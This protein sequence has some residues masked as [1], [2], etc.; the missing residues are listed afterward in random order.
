MATEQ[1]LMLLS[2]ILSHPGL[3]ERVE[4]I[5]DIAENTSGE[6]ITADQAEGKAIE[7]VQKLGLELLKEWAIQQQVKAIALAKKTHS[8]AVGH[9]KKNSTGNQRLEKSK[10][11]N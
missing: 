3:K 7:E 1:E 10:S 6:L 8:N 5:L 2:R 4:A 9:E 11:K